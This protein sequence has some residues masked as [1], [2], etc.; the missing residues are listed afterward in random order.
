[1]IEREI[2][3]PFA[4]LEA[5]RQA[6]V[7]AGGRLVVS[8]RPIDDRLFDTADGALRRA[9]RTLRVRRDGQRT[10]LTCKGPA[11][12]GLVKIREEFETEVGDAETIEA[13]IG[14]LGYRQTFRS[15]KFREEYAATDGASIAVDE[16]PI[17]VFVEI[18]GSEAAI[19]TTA[20]ALGRSTSDYVLD[21][22]PALHRAW[23]Q[24]HGLAAGDMLFPERAIL[25]R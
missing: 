2:K 21:S 16:T 4:D 9:G 6:V 14:A 20:T 11:P 3:L 12:P 15:Q 24:R 13:I 10:L 7:T 23:C 5:A 25:G 8:R 18:E 1:M 22:Y 19:I 17:G